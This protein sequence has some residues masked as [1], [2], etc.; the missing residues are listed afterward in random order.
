MKYSEGGQP[1]TGMASITCKMSLLL[2]I[3]NDAL[4]RSINT[5]LQN[6]PNGRNS[7]YHFPASPSAQYQMCWEGRQHENALAFY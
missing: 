6:P 2:K 4:M 7:K 1:A 5:H 3:D